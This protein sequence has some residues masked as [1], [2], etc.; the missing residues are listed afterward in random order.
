MHRHV[1]LRFANLGHLGLATS[2]DGRASTH[3]FRRA[4]D[5]GRPVQHGCSSAASNVSAITQAPTPPA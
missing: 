2:T 5:A 1:D 4:Q 3:A